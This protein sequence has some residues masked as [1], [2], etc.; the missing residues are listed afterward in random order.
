VLKVEHT[1]VPTAGEGLR[2]RV[3]ARR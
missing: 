2:V 1:P 3:V